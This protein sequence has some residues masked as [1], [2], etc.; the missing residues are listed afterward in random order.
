MNNRIRYR[1]EL[2]EF[3]FIVVT[4]FIRKDFQPDPFALEAG[5]QVARV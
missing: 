2:I 1:V 4:S 3:R 5:S